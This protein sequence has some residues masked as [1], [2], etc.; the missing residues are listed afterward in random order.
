MS[1][2]LMSAV[3]DCDLPQAETLVM[4][5]VAD[6]ANDPDGLAWPSV[7]TVA[8][9]ARLSERQARRVLRKLRDAGLLE[10]VERGGKTGMEG[11]TTVYR[12]RPDLGKKL[13]ERSPLRRP[14]RQRRQRVLPLEGV[15][16]V[17]P[18]GGHGRH[19]GDVMGDTQGVSPVTAE[20]SD[21]PS[22]RQ[23]SRESS[24]DDLPLSLLAQLQ[25]EFPAYELVVEDLAWIAGRI[26]ARA[27]TPPLSRK[28]WLKALRNFIRH[29]PEELRAW[30]REQEL[31]AELSIGRGPQRGVAA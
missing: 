5:A 17:T 6:H 20:S 28:Y 16:P 19:P 11:D 23:P 31:A 25:K 30:H 15:S 7:W 26:R 21:E 4:L 18:G 24:S 29:A 12:V 3:W 27:K 9:K 14:S 10:V 13:E 8:R 1:I 2:K 22:R